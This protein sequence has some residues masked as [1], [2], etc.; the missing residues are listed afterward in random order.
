MEVWSRAG[1]R[2]PQE[3]RR[4]RLLLLLDEGC[5]VRKA[6]AAVKISSSRVLLWKKR[7]QA[8]RFNGLNDRP[9]PGRKAKLTRAQKTKIQELLH[10]CAT[11]PLLQDFAK[12][13][14][15]SRMTISRY[16][17]RNQVSLAMNMA[18]SSG[19]PRPRIEIS[20]AAPASPG[21][22]QTDGAPANDSREK[23]LLRMMHEACDLHYKNR[24]YAEDETRFKAIIGLARQVSDFH[25]AAIQAELNILYLGFGINPLE[26]SA[27]LA[28]ALHRRLSLVEPDVPGMKAISFQTLLLR[29]RICERQQDF[30]G[31]RYFLAKA[32][33]EL[34]GLSLAAAPSQPMPKDA[35]RTGHSLI[36][37]HNCHIPPSAYHAALELFCGKNLIIEGLLRNHPGHISRGLQLLKSAEKRDAKISAW[38]DL[39]YD[40]LWQAPADLYFGNDEKA[41][42]CLDRSK[43]LFTSPHGLGHYFLQK[44]ILSA[45]TQKPGDFADYRQKAIEHFQKDFSWIGL[46]AVYE[47]DSLPCLRQPYG[48]RSS[49]AK[50]DRRLQMAFL[51]AVLDP[52]AVHHKALESCALQWLNC[53]DGSKNPRSCAHRLA[54]GLLNY[55]GEFNSIQPIIRNETELGLLKTGVRKAVQTMQGIMGTRSP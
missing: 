2:T 15:V 53:N 50:L 11:Q 17:R 35:V 6:A 7:W 10:G 25:P 3:A 36:V 40:L 13:F 27:S 23:A 14:A 38:E 21:W 16:L 1:G 8:D 48:S 26:T 5:S 30:S 29:A 49:F 46:G 19:I 34:A 37:P 20:A 47:N 52:S 42:F 28:E 31:I 12:R 18:T 41:E 22:P 24:N 51:A 45:H 32:S 43:E 55:E 39:G 4:A 9:R 44:A 54:E 33:R